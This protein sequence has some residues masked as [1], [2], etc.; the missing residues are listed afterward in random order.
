ME[1]TDIF[2]IDKKGLEIGGPSGAFTSIYNIAKNIDGLNFSTSTVWSSSNKE[3]GYIISN[4][5]IGNQYILDI[6]DITNI[7]DNTY[8]F[9]LSSHVI[10]HIANPMKA[11]EQCLSILKR[12]GVLVIIAPKKEVN[13]DHNRKTVTFDHVLDDYNKNTKETD[14]NHLD[15]IL[16]LHDLS[17]DIPA[18]TQEQFKERSLKNFENRCLHHHVFDLDILENIFKFFNLSI[19]KEL[20]RYN[21][22]VIVGQK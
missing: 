14:L 1:D 5:R 10:E 7:K 15:E 19:I 4:K 21:E 16:S 18:G 9:I 11:I 13:F 6:T 22:Y 2:F 20:V 17:M 8:D 12:D 3:L